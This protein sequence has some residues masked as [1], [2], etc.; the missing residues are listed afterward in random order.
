RTNTGTLSCFEESPLSISPRLRPNLPADEYLEDPNAGSVQRVRWS[1]NRIVLEVD[2]RVPTK[3][4]VNQNFAPGWRVDGGQLVDHFG[5]LAARVPAGKR[6]VTFTYLPRSF[7]IGSAVSLSAIAAGVGFVIFLRR[8][9][10]G[11]QG[12]TGVPPLL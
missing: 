8:R 4:L 1:P 2:A 5:L 12:G 11:H 6:T 10:R 7:L 3:V 9:R